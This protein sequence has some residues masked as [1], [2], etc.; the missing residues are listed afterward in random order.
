MRSVVD[1]NVV[2]WRIPVLKDTLIATVKNSYVRYQ[3]YADV[4]LKLLLLI[5]D[6]PYFCSYVK[7]SLF[8]CCNVHRG[9]GTSI[10]LHGVKS[11]VN[12]IIIIAA[13]VTNSKLRFD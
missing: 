5:C 2:M 13:A 6:V 9:K 3:L 4:R 10:T 11:Q 1:R 7:L 12:I 8:R